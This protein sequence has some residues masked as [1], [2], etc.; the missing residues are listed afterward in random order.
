MFVVSNVVYMYF[1]ETLNKSC[2]PGVRAEDD[3]SS[4]SCQGVAWTLCGNAVEIV[5]QYLKPFDCGMQRSCQYS[6]RVDK[7][8][9][10]MCFLGRERTFWHFYVILLYHSISGPWS[11]GFKQRVQVPKNLGGS[12]VETPL[13]WRFSPCY[14]SCGASPAASPRALVALVAPARWCWVK[15]HVS[16]C[17]RD[18]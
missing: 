14:S 5:Q 12:E 13:A 11:V 16:S 2:Q 9:I 17:A 18:F 10:W 15:S 1:Q 7:W 3:S 8:K 6:L 4:W